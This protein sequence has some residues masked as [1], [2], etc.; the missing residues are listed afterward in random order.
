MLGFLW[1]ELKNSLQGHSF[2]DTGW[3]FVRPTGSDL[4]LVFCPFFSVSASERISFSKYLP[5]F[6]SPFFFSSAKIY[7]PSPNIIPPFLL[8]FYSPPQ[9]I[10]FP[11]FPSFFFFS[12][13][14]KYVFL[15]NI[16]LIFFLGLS[17]NPQ[18]IYIFLKM[19]SSFSFS[20]TKNYFSSPNVFLIL[21]LC[22]SPLLKQNIFSFSKYFS[23]TPLH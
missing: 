6:P 2:P 22:S 8:C 19:F 1:T 11:P 13:T 7:S 5:P 17:S 3:F 18:K 10:Y 20:P 21:L 9:R 23:S 16:F 12:S 14:Q 15:S 4:S